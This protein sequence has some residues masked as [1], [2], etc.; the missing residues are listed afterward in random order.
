MVHE[1]LAAVAYA[2]A[3]LRA[4]AGADAA[5]AFE[6]LRIPPSASAAAQAP[7]RRWPSTRIWPPSG[8]VSPSSPNAWLAYTVSAMSST[9]TRSPASPIGGD[10]CSGMMHGDEG[11]TGAL[12]RRAHRA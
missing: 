2:C 8:R 1:N 12:A 3:G 7:G 6:H 10:R 11:V 4:D 9:A 5:A